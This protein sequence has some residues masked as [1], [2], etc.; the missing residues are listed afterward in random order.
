MMV[1]FHNGKTVTTKQ[2]AIYP[3]E[4]SKGCF[5]NRS[6]HEH[7]VTAQPVG[8]CSAL[9]LPFRVNQ[10]SIPSPAI[11]LFRESEKAAG[12]REERLTSEGRDK[13]GLPSITPKMC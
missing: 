2:R 7:T 9:S 11:Y 6:Q 8:T 3:Q 1:R 10:D 12:H 5:T 13:M 4:I